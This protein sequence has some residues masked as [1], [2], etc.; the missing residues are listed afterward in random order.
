M[1]ARRPDRFTPPGYD[2]R[3]PKPALLI[4][5]PTLADRTDFSARMVELGLSFPS[6]AEMNAALRDMVAKLDDEAERQR[7]ADH[8]A[9]VEDYLATKPEDRQP[10]PEETVRLDVEFRTI[11]R[12][13]YPPYARLVA[14]RVRWSNRAPIVAF[15]MFCVGWEGYAERFRRS[16]GQ[17]DEAAMDALPPDD[18]VAAGNRAL[19]LMSPS[20]AEAKNSAAPSPSPSGPESSTAASA[21]STAA[22]DGTSPAPSSS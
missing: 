6:D 14:R 3:D 9:A 15:Q 17:V 1:T 22:G 12:E 10:L 7:W 5:V 11:A 20:E 4:K 8:M 13:S 19:E 2:D 18:V 21:P 16:F